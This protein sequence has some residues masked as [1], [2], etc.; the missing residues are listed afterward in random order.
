M[1]IGMREHNANSDS[2]KFISFCYHLSLK[3]FFGIKFKDV[4]A[5]LRIVRRDAIDKINI[6]CKGPFTPA[7]IVIK[8]QESGYKIGT[9]P[10]NSYPRIHG[11][12]TSLS[13]K[14]FI[15]TIFEILK[16]FIQIKIK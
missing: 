5:A 9:I 8:V 12:S 16:V 10:I 3:L 4:S 6:T 14:N 7:E 13:P 1:V 2:R 11:K 15:K